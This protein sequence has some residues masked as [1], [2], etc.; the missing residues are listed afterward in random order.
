MD[1]L[2]GRVNLF[3]SAIKIYLLGIFY[4]LEKIRKVQRTEFLKLRNSLENRLWKMFPLVLSIVWR[5]LLLFKKISSGSYIWQCKEMN[6]VDFLYSALGYF[7]LPLGFYISS[8]IIS[9]NYY[10]C[11]VWQVFTGILIGFGPLFPKIVL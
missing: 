4:E 7:D 1:Y 9:C 6:V 3:L 10:W 5:I 2:W 11:L 8:R